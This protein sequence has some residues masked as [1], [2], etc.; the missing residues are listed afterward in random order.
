MCS[1]E[2][3]VSKLVFSVSNLSEN[4]TGTVL[5]RPVPP[6]RASRIGLDPDKPLLDT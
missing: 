4:V 3:R 5:D 1:N 2:N 6:S